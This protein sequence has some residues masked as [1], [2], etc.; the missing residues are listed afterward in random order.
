MSFRQIVPVLIK[1]VLTK[2][3]GYYKHMIC[4]PIKS[5]IAIR[6]DGQKINNDSE[7]LR[8]K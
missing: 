6:T 2:N 8:K 7:M 1:K 4:L 3:D 5:E